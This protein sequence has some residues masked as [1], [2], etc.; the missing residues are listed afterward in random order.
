MAQINIEP[1]RRRSALPFLI[2]ML[3]VAA[4][5]VGVW[6]FMGRDR[7]RSD[8]GAATSPAVTAPGGGAA[9]TTLR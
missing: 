1:R 8:D 7:L 9:D 2:G 4:I 3:L 5:A 6:Y